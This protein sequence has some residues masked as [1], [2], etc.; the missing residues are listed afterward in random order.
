MFWILHEVNKLH[1]TTGIK[2][3]LC[4]HS[5]QKYFLVGT[6]I[7]PTKTIG[8]RHAGFLDFYRGHDNLVYSNQAKDETCTKSTKVLELRRT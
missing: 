2:W 4:L 3:H 7:S 1:K 5:V 6:G 8:Y